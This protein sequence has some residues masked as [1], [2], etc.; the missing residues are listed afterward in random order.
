MKESLEKTIQYNHDLCIEENHPYRERRDLVIKMY[1]TLFVP[2]YC[3][4]CNSFLRY[5][6]PRENELKTK[7]LN[8]I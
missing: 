3:S 4:N 5:D 2:V 7:H 8:N 1:Q 6:I